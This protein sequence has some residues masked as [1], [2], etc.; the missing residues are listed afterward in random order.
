M[1]LARPNRLNNEFCHRQRCFSAEVLEVFFFSPPFFPFFL[2]LRSC[3][4]RSLLQRTL[5]ILVAVITVGKCCYSSPGY[6]DK[7]F[8]YAGSWLFGLRDDYVFIKDRLGYQDFVT[9]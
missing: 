5:S 7:S 6:Q 1:G 8:A 4:V 9:S 3:P 2:F